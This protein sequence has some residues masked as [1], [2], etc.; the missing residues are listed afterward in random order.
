MGQLRSPAAVQRGST[1]T[2]RLG[3]HFLAFDYTA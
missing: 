3:A 2:R 1:D